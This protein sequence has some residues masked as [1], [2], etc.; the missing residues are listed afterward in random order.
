MVALGLMV[1]DKKIFKDFKKI[2]FCCHGKQEFLKETN[3]F[4]KF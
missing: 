3:D 1:S 2:Q 4:K